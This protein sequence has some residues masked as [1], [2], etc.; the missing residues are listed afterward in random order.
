MRRR[1]HEAGRAGLGP[2]GVAR[3][4]RRLGAR[5]LGARRGRFLV[6]VPQEPCGVTLAGGC[7]G[8]ATH[9]QD[10]KR[11]ASASGPE[12]PGATPSRPFH[13]ARGGTGCD[14]L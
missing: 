10:G 9:S 12:A 2:R 1:E 14:H 11:Y 4:A 6:D 13:L 8:A 3:R 7:K 5:R